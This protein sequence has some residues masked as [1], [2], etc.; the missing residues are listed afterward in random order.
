[1]RALVTAAALGF[2]MLAVLPATGA[3]A[4]AVDADRKVETAA[5]RADPTTGRAWVEVTIAKRFANGKEARARGQAIAVAVPELSFDRATGV[6][7]IDSGERRF[8][9][10][11]LERDL[12]TTGECR[13]DARI[14][15]V[16]VDTGF[17]AATRDHLV[18]RV[19]PR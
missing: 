7:S 19:V 3:T 16:V 17:G 9:C 15:P 18:V 10:A 13:I 1:M 8:P 5:L 6:V 4:V 14:E 12:K 2:T 11:V